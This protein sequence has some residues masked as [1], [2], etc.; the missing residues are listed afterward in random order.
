M[1][2]AK[3]V[4]SHKTYNA[5]HSFLT[6][7]LF[8]FPKGEPITQYIPSPI[9]QPHHYPDHY[10]SFQPI[11]GQYY[12]KER[13]DTI[14]TLPTRRNSFLRNHPAKCWLIPNR[15]WWFE[16]MGETG[17]FFNKVQTKLTELNAVILCHVWC[18]IFTC[19]VWIKCALIHLL[20]N[21][22]HL[23]GLA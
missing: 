6:P 16:I 8:L 3:W 10:P 19:K 9:H 18:Y 20:R 1:T 17:K 21:K 22:W 15:D 13:G 4:E 23:I 12:G 5:L 11:N 7:I 14:I 2:L